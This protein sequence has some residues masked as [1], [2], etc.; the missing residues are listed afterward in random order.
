MAFKL[1]KTDD[2][3]LVLSDAGEPVYVDD[4]GKDFSFE[5]V[6]ASWG[7]RLADVSKEAAGHRKGKADAKAELQPWLDLGKTIDEVQE[8][9]KTAETLDLSQ[10][11]KA[12]EVQAKIKAATE[13]VLRDLDAAKKTYEGKLAEKDKAITSLS[14]DLRKT[15]ISNKFL[16][17]EFFNDATK[18]LMTPDVA[19]MVFGKYF[20]V[21]GTQAVCYPGGIDA[22]GNPVGE[23]MYSL[24]DPG[25]TAGFTEAIDKLWETYSMKDRYTPPVGSGDQPPWQRGGPAPQGGN[26]LDQADKAVASGNYRESIRLKNRAVQQGAFGG[27]PQP[28]KV[29]AQ[30]Q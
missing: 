14:S 13:Q 9:I 30:Q 23:P 4:A 19:E 7:N 27:S 8:A 20:R 17:S 28:N 12:T 21:E 29:P 2:G 15:L 1:K 26:L 10:Y 6:Q 18:T 5:D 22:D 25:K 11:T 24:K 16:G 3:Q